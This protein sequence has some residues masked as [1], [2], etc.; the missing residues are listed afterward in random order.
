MV[1][2]KSDSIPQDKASGYFAALDVAL[3]R[4]DYAAAARAQQALADLGWD[5]RHRLPEPH[6]EADG[7]GVA[8]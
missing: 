4:G 3:A 8:R 6:Q 1:R 7:R 2:P 5:V